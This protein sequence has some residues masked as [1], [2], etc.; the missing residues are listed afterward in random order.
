MKIFITL[1]NPN[2]TRY[3][4]AAIDSAQNPIYSD[5]ERLRNYALHECNPHM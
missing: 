5:S 1:L 2:Y 4:L 3:L